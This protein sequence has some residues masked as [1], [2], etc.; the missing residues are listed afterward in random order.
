[1][2][3]GAFV[4]VPAR[5]SIDQSSDLNCVMHLEKDGLE[6]EALRQFSEAL[7]S[8]LKEPRFHFKELRQPPEPDAY[9]EFDGQPLYLEVGHV[10]GTTAD[11]KQLLGRTGQSAPSQE[12]KLASAMIPLD[13]RILAPLNRLLA[14]KAT[15]KYRATRIWLLIRSAFPLWDLRDFQEHQSRILIPSRHPFE[16]IWLL[17][18]VKAPSGILRLA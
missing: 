2:R 1:M 10:Y 16:Q 7:C 13:L 3:N 6:S 9:C 18:G 17:C 5:T 4:A 14:K 15:K 11:I 8:E 12:D